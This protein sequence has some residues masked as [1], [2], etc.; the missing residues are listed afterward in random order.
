MQKQILCVHNVN[1]FFVFYFGCKN[2]IELIE[3]WASRTE[4]EL[5]FLMHFTTVFHSRF[6]KII[7]T[8]SILSFGCVA[9]KLLFCLFIC[10]QMFSMYGHFAFIELPFLCLYILNVGWL[11]YLELLSAMIKPKPHT[12]ICI[13]HVQIH[14][15]FYGELKMWCDLIYC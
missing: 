3:C 12:Y 15:I 4:M 9:K 11:N 14:Q 1:S 10:F 13:Q 2:V 8:R 6:D 7:S 5:L